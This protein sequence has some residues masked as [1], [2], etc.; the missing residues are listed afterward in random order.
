MTPLPLQGVRVLDLT[1]IVF[2]PYASQNLADYGADVIKIEPPEGDSTRRTGPGAEAGMGAIFLG[3]NRGK[4][5]VVL[6]LKQAGDREALLRLVE[7]ADVFMHSIRPQKLRALGLDPDTLRA[8]NP[9]LVYAGLHG[10]G[11]HGPYGGMPAY[12]DIVQGMAGCAALMERQTGQPQYYPTIA[13]DKTCAQVATHAIL[14]ALFA[15]ERTGQGSYV[16]V[17]MFEAMAAFN[18]VE[19]FYGHHFAP[20]R[21][22]CGYPRV[23]ATHRRPYRTTDGYVCML[24]YTD[25]HWRCFFEEAGLQQAAADPRFASIA[26]RTVHIEA[27]YA[28][29]AGAIATR[30]TAHWLAACE[31]LEIPAARMNELEDLERDPHLQATGFFRDLEDAELGHLRVPGPPVRIDGRALPATMPPRL[32]EHTAQ[33]LEQE[34]RH[35]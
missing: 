18:L 20:P 10:F 24:P 32:G 19:H 16:E 25:Q 28:L 27:L 9:R 3:V 31:R 29:A 34:R 17:P 8:R 23:L 22:D 13:A 14:A 4:R 2:G 5:S 12:D 35:P 15:R 1:S 30:S 21:G 26:Q 7:G 6:D 11:E 33:V